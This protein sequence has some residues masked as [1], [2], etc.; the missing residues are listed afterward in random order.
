[1]R[2]RGSKNEENVKTLMEL[3]ELELREMKE[4]K[5]YAEIAEVFGVHPSSVAR[6]YTKI[7]SPDMI[8]YIGNET[9]TPIEVKEPY[10][11]NEDD[12]G[13]IGGWMDSP[14][15]ITIKSVNN[16]HHYVDKIKEYGEVLHT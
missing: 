2:W 6:V 3:S 15:R 8:V 9:I 16:E 13:N 5:T 11:T 12:Y 1:M 10:S 4:N 7:F 14:H